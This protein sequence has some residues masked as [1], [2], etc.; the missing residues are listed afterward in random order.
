MARTISVLLEASFSA[1][2]SWVVVGGFVASGATP[3]FVFF[4]FSVPSGH[5]ATSEGVLKEVRTLAILSLPASATSGEVSVLEL[6][7][8][9]SQMAEG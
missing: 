5:L 3:W 7:G 6:D 4:F 9:D 2:G 1:R 8:T